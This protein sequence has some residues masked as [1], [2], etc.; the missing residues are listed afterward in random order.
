MKNG[1]NVIA[2]FAP[3]AVFGVDCFYKGNLRHAFKKL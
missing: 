1:E 3:E 2:Y